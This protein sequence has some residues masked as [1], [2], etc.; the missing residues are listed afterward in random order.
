MQ[1]SRNSSVRMDRR[2]QG[3]VLER[4]KRMSER[5]FRS[6]ADFF[7]GLNLIDSLG[8][9]TVMNIGLQTT[10][11]TTRPDPIGAFLNS[12]SWVEK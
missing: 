6:E 8:A 3:Q 12:H 1:E 11:M 4:W 2:V 7:K 9:D 10:E 5:I